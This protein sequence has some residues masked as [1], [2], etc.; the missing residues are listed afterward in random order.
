MNPIP[1]KIIVAIHGI[2]DQVRCETIQ[3]VAR[4]FAAYC[5]VKEDIPLGRLNA[6]L[7][8]MAGDPAPIELK[9]R[10][11]RMGD[12]DVKLLPAPAAETG[13]CAY[14]AQSPPFTGTLGFAEV[15]WADIP[16]G[17]A[18][19]G[20]NLEEAKRWATTVVD[21]VRALGRKRREE[22]KALRAATIPG[23]IA[24]QL[25]QIEANLPTD[26]DYDLAANVVGELIET[27]GGMQ[28]LL[29]W[30]GKAMRLTFD[31]EK[32][33]VDYPAGPTH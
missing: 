6:T 8:P 31:L 21:R 29:Y 11:R 17:L 30:L 16:R 7:I 1:N 3:L 19:D 20:Y 15:Y 2:G 26:A 5:A 22:V 12:L 24:D 4:R 13:P 23:K 10:K 14:L 32:I 18:K 25:K 9:V 28:K 33:L 27:I